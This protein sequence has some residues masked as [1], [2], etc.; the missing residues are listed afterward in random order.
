[1]FDNNTTVI[2]GMGRNFYS[3]VSRLET[4]MEIEY[5]CDNHKEK[6]GIRPFGDERVCIDPEKIKDL[7]A[8]VVIILPE[9][10]KNIIEI[11]RQCKTWNIPSYRVADVLNQIENADDSF[12]WLEKIQK[13]RIHKFI[14]IDLRGTTTCNFHCAYCYVWRKTEFQ[15]GI[16]TS[17]HSPKEIR[18]ALSLKR[19]GGTCFINLCA[20]GE[21]MLSKDIIELVYE[22]LEEG[23]LVSV[24]TNG[25]ITSNIEKI[26]DFPDELQ[27]R[28]FFKISF[29]FDEL[30]KRNL[31][32]HFWENV[33]KIKNSRCSYTLE[34]T[35]YDGIVEKIDE[36]K[37]I[38]NKKADGG[39]PHISFA[40]DS[41][42]N[43]LDLLSDY[44][45]E[46][47]KK[48]WGQF[49]SPMFELKSE[50][51]G[52]KINHY[53]HAGN[54]SYLI[55]IDTGD[56]RPCYR[57]DVI[58]N[59]F[60][61]ADENL[62][63][64]TIGCD[65]NMPYCFNNHAFLAWGC[66]PEIECDSY[67]A[68]R[69]RKTKT[70]ECWVKPPIS[71]M[72]QGKLYDNNYK[73]SEQWTDYKRLYLKD[74][75]P[76]V[77]LFNSPDYANLGDHAIALAE[78]VFFEKCFPYM[79]FIEVSCEQYEKE[80]LN[81][82]TA[83]S[84]DDIIVISGGGNLGSL[85]LWIEDITLH[86]IN[87]FQNNKIFIF[88][89]TLFFENTKLG[90]MEKSTFCQVLNNH[91]H[92]T[93][94]LRDEESYKTAKEILGTHIKLLLIPDMAFGLKYPNNVE[95]N[96][97]LLCLRDDKEKKEYADSRLEQVTG[98]SKIEFKEI[99]TIA[100]AEVYLNNREK[101]L[102]AMLQKISQAQIVLTD[103]LHCMIFCAITGTPCVVFDNLSG[104]VFGAYQ[105]IESLKYIVKYDA[106]E[107]LEKSICKAMQNG[108]TNCACKTIDDK[109]VELEKFMR[110]E[111]EVEMSGR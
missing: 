32:E 82:Q 3:Y 69:D 72:M 36:I 71:Y 95:R 76:A 35:P 65:C 54:W 15:N 47:Y 63:I 79:Q 17:D 37:E 5:I 6:W 103:R 48:I 102:Y 87:T 18:K 66:V 74:R 49:E 92:L 13:Y 106:E 40:R 50:W 84:K 58:A 44:S 91:R 59:I 73:H 60:E 109:F 39:M 104:K 34:I 38:F 57:Q 4:M 61:N 86:I 23:H 81:I 20:R 88:P 56:V 62:P 14:D 28:M 2:W 52:K 100:K 77:I 78:K 85:W 111:L 19:L 70:G 26:L 75:K 64:A 108:K 30:V 10:E 94:M 7:K 43:G 29:H 21:T 83:V 89:Q 8:P 11:E 68:M 31:M 22:L 45:I 46:E 101:L 24:V 1:M 51:Y 107:G 41:R 99:S 97:G 96:G 12:E 80:N 42:K 27:S 9:R 25:T 33:N 110:K 98:E 93:L 67:F 55:N 90:K 16:K 105:W 53:C